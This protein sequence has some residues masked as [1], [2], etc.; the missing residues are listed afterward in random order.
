MVRC[1]SCYGYD[2]INIV[3]AKATENY[4]KYG[5]LYGFG[6]ILAACPSGWHLPSDSEWKQMEIQLGMSQSD[7]NNSSWRGTNQD[8]M[9]KALS[10]WNS[11][12]N[13]TNS[14]GFSTIPGGYC[15][16]N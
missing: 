6:A 10:G 5:V 14:S 11:S 3:E 7:A 9:L 1:I 13:G 8:S 15:T 4:S 12:E 16:P 2:G